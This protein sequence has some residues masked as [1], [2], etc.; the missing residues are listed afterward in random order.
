MN[1]RKLSTIL[2]LAAA[3]LAISTRAAD[4]N[5]PEQMTY[6]GFLADANGAGLA[7]S[8][9]LNYDA[10]FRIYDASTGGN[11]LWAESQII[12]VDKGLFSV[13]L[14]QGSVNASEPRPSLSSVFASTS[15]SDRFIAINVKVGATTMDILPRLRLVPGA[16]SFLARNANNLVDSRGTNV[17]N[18]VSP[19]LVGINKTPTTALD[20][21]GTVTATAFAGNGANLTG[22]TTTQIPNLDAAKITTGSIADARLSG[23]VSLLN[24]SPQAFSGVNTFASVGINTATPTG[25]L[26]VNGGVAVTGASSPYAAGTVGVFME[27]SGV[28][29]LYA[30][31][32][33]VGTTKTLALQAPG[34]SVGIGTTDPLGNILQI[35]N[36]FHGANGFALVANKSDYGVNIQ[37][38]RGPGQ[39]GG[40]LFIDNSALGDTTPL[41]LVR[42]GIGTASGV[43]L[44]S[45]LANGTVTA[46]GNLG[47]GIAPAYRLD[48]NGIAYVRST[49]YV[50]GYIYNRWGGAY[51]ALINGGQNNT[52]IWNTSDQRLKKDVA[53]IENALDVLGQL[54]GVSY[55]WNEQGVGHLTRDIEKAWRS[56]SGKDEDNQK[57]WAEK[58]QEAIQRL[59]TQQT[60]FVAQE[61]EKVFPSWVRTDDKGFKQINVDQ[62]AG[63]IVQGVNELNEKNKAQESEIKELRVALSELRARDKEREDRLAQIERSLAGRPVVQKADASARDLIR[64]ER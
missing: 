51:Y 14:G 10:I 12:T 9:P 16:Y 22:L 60:G 28:G 30:Y 34:G 55:H 20:V 35:G 42:N 36:R 48:V 15:A 49:L 56:A 8:N 11:L 18:T 62:L 13:I 29:N 6:Q 63:V 44:F 58:K 27:Y 40:G 41:L 3:L 54:R 52:A 43:D 19:G 2:S 64:V 45:I 53:T 39:G 33:N 50:D 59:N 61:V 24:R 37:V 31:D 7:P 1:L 23:N 5:P 46:S 17:I 57:L 47:L 25:K 26:H 32:Y 21:N 4:N 38:N